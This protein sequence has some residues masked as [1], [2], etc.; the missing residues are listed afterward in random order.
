[1]SRPDGGDIRLQAWLGR[2]LLLHFWATWC[3]PCVR[4]LPA[5]DAW[6]ARQGEQ[7]WRVL[8]IAADTAEAVQGFAPARG[9]HF[10]VALAG[11]QGLA[12]ARE[13]GNAQGGLPFSVALD[14]QGRARWHKRGATEAGDLAALDA[15]LT[16]LT[17]G[18]DRS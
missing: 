15:L 9:L 2:P 10:P 13:L 14:G 8:G 3:A 7:G 12:L 17:S 16:E 18:K 6:A 5:L 11:T 4:E 1:M